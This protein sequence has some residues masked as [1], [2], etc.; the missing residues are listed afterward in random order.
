MSSA[1]D[2][3]PQRRAAYEVLRRV[4]EHEAWADRALPAAADRHGLDRRE[5]AQ[6]QRLAYGAVQRRGTSDH[7]IAELAERPLRKLDPPVLAALR[8]GL[9]ELVFSDATPD[10]AAVDEAVELAKGSG[11]RRRQAGAGLVNAVLRRAAAARR[12][13]VR[14]ATTRHRRAPR[15]L[16]SCPEWLARLWWEELGRARGTLAAGGHQRARGDRAPRQHAEGRARSACSG[17]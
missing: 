11:G 8:L 9:F 2:V 14:P 4:F 5:R 13:P 7:L 17:S 16:H 3:A 6:A 15:S 10:H 1:R 12:P